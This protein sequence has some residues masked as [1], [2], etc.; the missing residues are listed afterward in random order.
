[1]GFSVMLGVP[2]YWRELREDTGSDKRLHS[3]IKQCD[4]I[5]PWFVGRYDEKSY[6]GFQKLIRKDIVWTRKNGVDYVPL[7][8][9]GFSWGN[10]KGGGLFI[11]RNKG[12][13]FWKQL[14]NVIHSGAGMIYIA[15]FDELDEGTAIFKCATR[16]P[17]SA[18]GSTFVPLEEETGGDY[19]LRLAGDA[20]RLLRKELSNKERQLLK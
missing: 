12:T 19:Y 18:E 16:V 10:M 11:P 2:T 9:P 13:F 1:M 8:Y 6:S 4:I 20:G 3:L 7:C 17:L 15:M 14:S 5:M